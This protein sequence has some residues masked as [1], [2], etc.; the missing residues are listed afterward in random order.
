MN[1]MIEGFAVVMGW[2]VEAAYYLA[3]GHMR[4]A[5]VVM[6]SMIGSV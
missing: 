5:N 1:G 3:N 2:C 4:V 6:D